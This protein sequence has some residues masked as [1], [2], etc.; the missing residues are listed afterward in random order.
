MSKYF[1]LAVTFCPFLLFAGKI[2]YS[3]D[4]IGLSN[5]DALKTIK[6]SS[7]L[8]LLRDK[9]PDSINALRY[10]AESDIPELIKALQS[11]GYY[12]ASISIELEEQKERFKFLF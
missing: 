10:K 8:V 2:N 5:K 3:V 11:Y 12:E 9:N 7:H 6:N 1:F 4:F